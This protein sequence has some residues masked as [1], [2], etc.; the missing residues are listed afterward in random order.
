M[1]SN[2]NDLLSSLIDEKA[3]SAPEHVN[4][5]DQYKNSGKLYASQED[6]RSVF[7]KNLKEKR[8]RY[9][10]LARNLAVG[11][12]AKAGD[13]SDDEDEELSAME[14]D[15]KGSKVSNYR[16]KIPKSTRRNLY[17][18]QLMLS[19][20]M[21]EIPS[22]FESK[23]LIKLCPM[24]KRCLVVASNGETKAY[25]RKNGQRVNM[26]S[27]L[28]PGGSKDY[29]HK[30]SNFTILDCCY[31]PIEKMFYI[32]DIMCWNGYEFYDSQ[33]EFR[34][35][36][37]ESKLK[38]TPGLNLK[39][40]QNWFPFVELKTHLGDRE[41]L[42]R[43]LNSELPFKTDLDGVLFFHKE[44]HYIL[45]ATPIVTWLKPFMIPEVFGVPVPESF[46]KDKPESY[47]SFESFAKSEME[48]INKKEKLKCLNE[49]SMNID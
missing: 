16:K 34:F 21:L 5:L 22:D 36:W 15:I 17:R 2:M 41:T 37:L 13:L 12:V 27:S 18:N 7:L 11:D 20:W 32:L 48:K 10:N 33:A 1:A 44:G 19:E 43:I 6:R 46:Y 4:R 35:Y 28:L 14:C 26:F 39:S 45:G 8:Q 49:I 38:E 40:S 9:V 30:S 25:S 31:S 24:A 29:S 42:H 23:W 47:L 3:E